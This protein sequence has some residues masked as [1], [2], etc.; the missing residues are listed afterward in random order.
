MREGLWEKYAIFFWKWRGKHKSNGS[1]GGRSP[2]GA[3]RKNTTSVRPFHGENTES[4][5]EEPYVTDL[6]EDQR[7]EILG[8]VRREEARAVRT[9]RSG[10]VA[11][12]S[13]CP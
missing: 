3:N 8:V 10:L 1:E 13:V 2:N 6:V 9:A 7:D 11:L 4:K 5:R 12:G